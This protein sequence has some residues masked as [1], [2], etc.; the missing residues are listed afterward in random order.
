MLRATLDGV[1][2]ALR[3]PSGVDGVRTEAAE[4]AVGVA[5]RLALRVVSFGVRAAPVDRVGVAVRIVEAPVE[6]TARAGGADRIGVIDWME[7]L[8]GVEGVRVAVD[9]RA[10]ATV[11]VDGV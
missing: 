1:A 10:E 2:V 8:A 4:E 6:E 5:K 3:T 7:L 11:D 9:E